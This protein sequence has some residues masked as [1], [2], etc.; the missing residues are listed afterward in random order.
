MSGVGFNTER[1]DVLAHLEQQRSNCAVMAKKSPEFADEARMRER[2]FEVL[3]E[4]FKQGLHVG[5]A[6][7]A[8]AIA[9]PPN[10]SGGAL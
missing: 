6:D 4:Y 1:E 7:V 5:C 9:A 10:V 8:A 3:I 2:Q